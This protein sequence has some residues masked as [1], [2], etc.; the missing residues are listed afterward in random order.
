MKIFEGIE[1]EMNGLEWMHGKVKATVSNLEKERG[2]ITSDFSQEKLDRLSEGSDLLLDIG[3]RIDEITV[4]SSAP[5]EGL[6]EGSDGVEPLWDRFIFVMTGKELAFYEESKSSCPFSPGEWDVEIDSEIEFGW[7][8]YH[9]RTEIPKKGATRDF[10]THYYHRC[11]EI[12]EWKMT[13]VNQKGRE[14]LIGSIEVGQIDAFCSV[15][16]LP[17]EMDSSTAASRIL[18]KSKGAKQWQRRVDRKRVSAIKR[19]IGSSGDNL[20]ANSVILYVPPDTDAVSSKG[21]KVII[22]PSK[23]LGRTRSSGKFSSRRGRRDLRPIWIIDGQH[24]TRGLAQSREGI[25]MKVPVILFPSDFKLSEA[26]KIFSEINTLQV[27]LSPLHKLFMQHRFSIAH[28]QSTRDFS[29]PWKEDGKITNVNSRANHMAYECA[30]ALSAK[31]GGALFNRI[32]FLDSNSA[33]VTIMKANSWVDYARKWFMPGGAYAPDTPQNQKW[34]NEEVGNFFEAFR[35][36]SNHTGWKKAGAPNPSRP[37]WS[38]SSANKGVIH[39]HS[40]S[41]ALLM[42]Y[43]KAWRKARSDGSVLTNE[44]VPV[45]RFEEVLA[46][47]KWCDWLAP[48]VNEIYKGAGE[49]PRTALILWMEAAIDHGK[50]YEYSEVMSDKLRSKPGRGFLAPSGNG[51]LTKTSE[52]D[53]PDSKTPLSFRAERPHHA[54]KTAMILVRDGDGVDRV[55]MKRRSKDGFFDFELKHQSWM[56]STDRI[57]VRVSW[58]NR[59]NPPGFKQIEL[60]KP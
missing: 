13:K 30:A 24:R 17:K 9:I 16:Q 43:N 5:D 37:R 26:A 4:D 27:N 44:I 58:N 1:D 15:P 53:W 34:V 10:A 31:E 32:Q 2:K 29:F 33:N 11:P 22:D 18:N 40:S 47:L 23:Y 48:E 21:S 8:E 38:K 6:E 7:H 56:K 49:P 19:F 39:A 25:S 42:I 50:T 20:I 35:S 54:F 60:A 3:A 46:P 41:K 36:T 59:V 28:T 45:A 57:D 52:E 55:A 14:F 51:K 12:Q